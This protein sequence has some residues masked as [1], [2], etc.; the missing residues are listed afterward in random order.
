MNLYIVGESQARYQ[1]PVDVVE[2]WRL[3]QTA[4][5][6]NIGLHNRVWAA[7][8][9]RLIAWGCGSRRRLRLPMPVDNRRDEGWST[10]SDT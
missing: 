8:G 2:A 10:N 4:R 3:E 1:E 5:A 9:E 7:S 6:A